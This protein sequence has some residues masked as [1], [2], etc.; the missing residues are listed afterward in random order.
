MGGDTA[1]AQAGRGPWIG[2]LVVG[3]GLWLTYRAVRPEPRDR[4]VVSTETI[5]ALGDRFEAEH[6]RP[7]TP[8]ELDGLVDGWVEQEVM[9][10]EARARGLDRADP[11]VRRRLVQKLG[12]VLEDLALTEPPDDSSLD[13]YR[14]HN[15]ERY[16]HAPRRGFSQV[17]VAGRSD[18]ARSRAQ[19]LAERVRQ[20]ESPQG[21]GEPFAHGATQPPA[22]VDALDARYGADFGAAVFAVPDGGVAVLGS[23]F[24]WHVIRPRP[25]VPGRLPPL[26]EVRARVLADWWQERRQQARR[27][28][29]R[30]LVDRY[31]VEV[32][33]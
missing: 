19:Q 26:S 2:L 29:A 13:A 24:G 15:A 28:G 3:V 17:F 1:R 14:K 9:V 22:T 23:V 21:L 18:Q 5:A 27:E 6:R 30:A 20:G 12:F 7:P 10:R 11:I 4:V 32:K 25:V 8:T 31:D 16:R 33:R